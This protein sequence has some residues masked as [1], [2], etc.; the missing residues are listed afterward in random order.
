MNCC[1]QTRTAKR[2][3]PRTETTK[4][5]NAIQLTGRE[6]CCS[7]AEC[8]CVD[9]GDCRCEECNCEHRPAA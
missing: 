2:P 1:C 8:E 9:S 3:P 5:P 6:R 4:P 7:D